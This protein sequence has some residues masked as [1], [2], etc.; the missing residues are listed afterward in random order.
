MIVPTSKDNEQLKWIWAYGACLR[1]QDEFDAR[2]LCCAANGWNEQRGWNAERWRRFLG[3]YGLRQ[4]Y[5]SEL[6][7]KGKLVIEAIEPIFKPGLRSDAIN[8][9]NE[10]WDAGTAELGR[11]V[12]NRKKNGEPIELCSMTSKLLWFYQPDYMTMYDKL[13]G[14]GLGMTVRNGRVLRC[15]YLS[16]F[17]SLYETSIISV[18]EAE[19]FHSR[20]VAY[21]RRVVDQWLWLHGKPNAERESLLENFRMSWELSAVACQKP[22]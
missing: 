8:D 19:K 21:K 7:D 9:L 4:G 17:N 2:G 6:R 18:V 1:L 13:A 16:A 5:H 10:R 3:T 12:T 22:S 11:I 20:V 14:K 15:E